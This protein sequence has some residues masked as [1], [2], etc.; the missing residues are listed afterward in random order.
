MLDVERIFK[1]FNKSK[2]DFLDQEELYNLL[3]VIDNKI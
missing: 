3:K 2:S 1:N